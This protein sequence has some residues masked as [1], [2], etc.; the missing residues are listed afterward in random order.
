M[1]VTDSTLLIPRPPCP[2]YQGFILLAYFKFR[3]CSRRLHRPSLSMTFP[4]MESTLF[5]RVKGVE[6]GGS[7]AENGRLPRGFEN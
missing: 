5:E 3:G 7:R 6:L 2:V 1:I 4:L